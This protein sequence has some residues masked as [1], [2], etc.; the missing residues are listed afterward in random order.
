[1]HCLLHFV[2][3]LLLPV[4]TYYRYKELRKEGKL[5]KFME[6]RRKKNSSKD[7]RFLPMRRTG[8]AGSAGDD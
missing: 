3:S 4:A 6:K 1:M 2:S 5:H 8:S 7:H